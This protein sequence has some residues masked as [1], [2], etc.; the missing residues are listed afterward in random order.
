[1]A[2]LAPLPLA[3][4]S[5]IERAASSTMFHAMTPRVNVTQKADAWSAKVLDMNEP[6]QSQEEY[7]EAEAEARA[8]AALKRMLATPHKPHKASKK[9]NG[10]SREK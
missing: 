8:A 4:E 7:S 2:A 10:E 9:G 3:W 6:D 1:M 5:R